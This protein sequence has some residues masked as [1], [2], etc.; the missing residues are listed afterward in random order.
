MDLLLDSLQWLTWFILR[1]AWL[2]GSASIDVY[3][4]CVQSII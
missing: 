4:V 3:S 2:D 1:N